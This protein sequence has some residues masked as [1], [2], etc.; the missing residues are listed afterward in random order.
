MAEHSLTLHAHGKSALRTWYEKMLG[1]TP[2]A[3]TKSHV[4]HG[5]HAVRASG[6]SL[7]IGGA[8]GLLDC[9][10]KSGLDV[11]VYTDKSGK[12]H[13]APLDGAIAAIGAIAGTAMANE[14]YGKDLINVGAG[15]AAI[16][17]YR[18]SRDFMA[19]KMRAANQNVGYQQ[20]PAFG[21]SIGA[22]PAPAASSTAHGESPKVDP[23]IA[24]AHTL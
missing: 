2:L 16:F 23:I 21:A 11:P 5:M 1:E 12:A 10:L 20:T 19:A 15:A 18:K 17:A 22:A 14:E 9:K 3:R 13:T 7:V 4:A 8:L 6:E 24:L